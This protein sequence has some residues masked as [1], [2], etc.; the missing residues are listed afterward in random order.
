MAGSL[1]AN[2]VAAAL[3]SA[4]SATDNSTRQNAEQ[5][6]GEMTIVEGFPVCLA[7]IARTANAPVHLRLSAAVNLKNFVAKS[8]SSREFGFV[9]TEPG[10]EAKTFI[11]AVVLAGLSDS[12]SRIRVL[13]A[14]IATKIANIEDLESWPELFTSLMANLKSGGPEQIHGA[15]R[16]ISSFVDDI[17]ETQFSQIAPVLLPQVYEIFANEAFNPRI[18]SRAVSVFR[19]FLTTLKNVEK[20]I[21]NVVSQ[22]LEPQLPSWMSSFHAILAP[23]HLSNEQ[24]IFKTEIFYTIEFL[25]S[26]FPIPMKTYLPETI[27]IV[28]RTASA[29]F[30][31]YSS[32]SIVVNDHIE[33]AEE[34]DTDGDVQGIQ[35]LL[36]NIF[37]ILGITAEMKSMG[38]MFVV[39]ESGAPSDFL[40][41]LV[42][43]AVS[44]AQITDGQIADWESDPSAFIQI[45]EDTA[46][47]FSMRYAVTMLFEQLTVRHSAKS[48][49]ALLDVVITLHAKSMA[50]KNSGD[51]NWWRLLESCLYCLCLE[52]EAVIDGV[53]AGKISFDFSGFFEHV[54]QESAKSREYPLLQGRALVFISL[55]STFIPESQLVHYIHAIATG[56]GQDHG[57]PCRISAIRALSKLADKPEAVTHF[58][59]FIGPIIE[60]I[61]SM[62]PNAA[63]DFLLLLLETLIP[64]VKVDG[65]ATVKYEATLVPLLVQVWTA[66]PD[67]N[68]VNVCVMNVF[69]ILSKNPLMLEAL[70]ARLLPPLCHSVADVNLMNQQSGIYSS[71]VVLLGVL[72][73]A[74]SSPLPPVYM[75]SVFPPL[76]KAMMV[77]EDNSILQEG[78]DCLQSLV[79]KD[80]Q[81]VVQWSDGVKNGLGYILDIIARLI[82]P[83]SDE[84]S[85]L[86]VGTLITSVIKKGEAEIL[87]ILPNLLTAIVYRLA[88]A[89]YTQLIET[90]IL[91]FAN[92]ILQHGSATIVNFLS[93]ISVPERNLN[94]LELLL[95]VWGD[96]FGEVNGFYNVKLNAAAM[97]T[98]F[99][100]S[101][102]DER[103]QKVIVKGRLKPTEKI[104]TRSKS[105][106]VPDQYTMIPFPAKAVMLL[107]ADYQQNRESAMKGDKGGMAADEFTGETADSE[108]GEEWDDLD[109]E[110]GGDAFGFGDGWGDNDE[111][112]DTTD[113]ELI[114][115]DVYDLNMTEYLSSFIISCATNNV[116]NFSII[117]DQMLDSGEKKILGSILSQK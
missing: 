39:P 19:K 64:L 56:L 102:S 3:Q 25:A 52:H 80:F 57:L 16:V 103:V 67:D 81:A 21:P 30:P 15:L 77:S 17:S 83:G 98:L 20:V 32:T 82:R 75:T 6:L 40:R 47:S 79:L 63:D 74:S 24:I 78:Q 8:W 105:K 115:K 43:A 35:S 46:P 51:L 59:Q 61:C 53:K 70:Q 49:Q 72:I 42:E 62:L 5:V 113:P 34:V 37:S 27:P 97:A 89:K 65:A 29:L 10:T 36:F 4:L 1:D 112:E 55:Y 76:I 14:A 13:M 99:K 18:R 85:C 88:T 9:G 87:P 116:S 110:E 86:Y 38:P 111:E 58:N 107:L 28:W 12:E 100:D 114:N 91:V 44:Y 26:D 41:G 71:S 73:R 22:Y 84:S 48:L 31:I 23:M 7:E 104:I 90:L 69:T 101:G 68:L 94:G 117:S 106:N 92:L 109:D 2:A 95:T 108:D 33:A 60:C 96:H 45:E 93:G 66:H 11:K 54:I 50:S